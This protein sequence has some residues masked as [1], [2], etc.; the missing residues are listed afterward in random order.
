MRLDTHPRAI[1]VG[2]SLGGLTA[3]LVLRD[4]AWDVEVYE[5]STAPLEGRGAGI[6]V[7]PA[8][9]RYLV[10][11]SSRDVREMTARARWV[12]YLDDEGTVATESPCRFRFT[13]YYALHRDL[14]ACFDGARYHLGH[15]VVAFDQDPDGVTVHLADGRDERCDLLVCADGI[16]STA[17]R[18]LLPDVERRYAGYVAW[19][20]TVG[21]SELTATTFGTLHEAITYFV[22]PGTHILAY[23][24]PSVDGSVDPGRRFTNWVWYW[25][26]EA[27]AL[28]ELM[29]GRDGRRYGVSIPAGAVEHRHLDG[30]RRVAERVLPPP[31]AEMVRKTREPFVQVVFDIEVSR[32][33]F[34]RVCLIGDAA[35]V[36]RPHAAV[37]TAKAAEDSWNLALAIEAAGHDVVE[38]LARWEPSQLALG[39]RALAR[40][41]EAGNRSQFE[42]AWRIGD[43]LPFGL[44]EAGDSSIS[45][46]WLSDGARR[47]AGDGAPRGTAAV[48]RRR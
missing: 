12:R 4:A 40:T 24:I 7:H 5:R 3:A 44:Y 36:L 45:E 15:R 29:T 39:R 34:G 28:D 38:A 23:P 47:H 2:G 42:N 22:A 21:E 1:V 37:G 20:G 43:P 19:R 6:V 18:L 41:R 31:L 17:R 27:A 32:M 8:S 13:S 35:F 16:H 25:N 11:R 14:L 26:V 33:A 30:L 46:E 9:V 48:P 10:E